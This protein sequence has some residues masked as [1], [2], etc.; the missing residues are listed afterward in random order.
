MSQEKYLE[1]VDFMSPFQRMID[2]IS[3]SEANEVGDLPDDRLT[4]P[5]VALRDF[6]KEK[7]SANIQAYRTA[8]AEVVARYLDEEDVEAILA[9]NK[10]A[11]GQKLM[12]VSLEMQR[13]V[14]HAAAKWRHETLEAHQS[15]MKELIGVVDPAPAPI[16]EAGTEKVAAGD[17]WTEIDAPPTDDAA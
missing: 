16:E 1:L 2:A 15:E 6:I 13:D 14:M 11:A 7:L 12:A 10:S 8:A 9:Y 17:G 3:L 5:L 4:P